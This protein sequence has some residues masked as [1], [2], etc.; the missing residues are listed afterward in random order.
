MTLW[1]SDVTKD[2]A[3]NVKKF[4]ASSSYTASPNIL[5]IYNPIC[6]PLLKID[7]SACGFSGKALFKI[8]IHWSWQARFMY[9]VTQVVHHYNCSFNQI[10]CDR[11][12]FTESI[13]S[14]TSLWRVS[15]FYKV[16]EIF[17]GSVAFKFIRLGSKRA[18]SKTGPSRPTFL[19]FS[20]ISAYQAW[21]IA[22]FSVQMWNWRN[23]S[24]VQHIA[25]NFR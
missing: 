16:G 24:C 22:F 19:L 11:S 13:L 3:G 10:V 8:L 20:P 7:L 12:Q 18:A 9:D 5:S 4:S 23:T 1:I 14:L 17:R 25:R 2:S 6:C 15:V 21:Q